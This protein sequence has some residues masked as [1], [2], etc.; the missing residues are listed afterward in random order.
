MPG[1]QRGAESVVWPLRLPPLGVHF[2]ADP[3]TDEPADEPRDESQRPIRRRWRW[4]LAVLLLIA[5]GVLVWSNLQTHDPRFLG[6]W[7]HATPAESGGPLGFAFRPGGDGDYIEPKGGRR[8]IRWWSEGDVL[9][10][11]PAQSPVGRVI[12]DLQNMGRAIVGSHHRNPPVF[13]MLIDR[14]NEH[15]I[16]YRTLPRNGSA[17]DINGR[18]IVLQ[19]NGE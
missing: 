6:R 13:R 15:E 2:R 10:I 3:M 1:H 14:I 17:P 16:Q 19:R 11:Q 9:C 4:A 12:D 5:G 18:P 8:P 7:D